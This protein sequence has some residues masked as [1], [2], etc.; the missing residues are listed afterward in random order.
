M[1]KSSKNLKKSIDNFKTRCYNTDKF[2]KIELTDDKNCCNGKHRKDE[3]I[4]TNAYKDI[5]V[6]VIAKTGE[7]RT[8]ETYT[9]FQ[10][11]FRFFWSSVE[12]SRYEDCAE[13]HFKAI[14][15]HLQAMNYDGVSMT[16]HLNGLTEVFTF[17]RWR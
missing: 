5:E 2:K 8:Y 3:V 9:D 17:K 11:D 14:I 15:E 6:T 10:K 13:K 7:S 16:T 1:K 12:E 4:M